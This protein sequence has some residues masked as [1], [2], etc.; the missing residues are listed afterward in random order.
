[1]TS[2]TAIYLAGLIGSNLGAIALLLT[3]NNKTT[4]KYTQAFLLASIFGVFL[5]S[6][7]YVT[8]SNFEI[9]LGVVIGFGVFCFTAIYRYLNKPDKL[10]KLRPRI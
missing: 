8:V 10:L 5:A 6:V 7:F 4:L 2:L 3:P 1:M 9:G